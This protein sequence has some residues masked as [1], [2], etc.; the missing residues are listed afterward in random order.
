MKAAGKRT[1]AK[2]R[3]AAARQPDLFATF[4]P[5][6]SPDP[7]EAPG[8]PESP[9]SFAL[10]FFDLGK[11]KACAAS[12]GKD[13]LD[14]RGMPQVLSLTS[15]DAFELTPDGE[16]ATV[17]A[18]PRQGAHGREFLELAQG[19]PLQTRTTLAQGLFARGAS[20][21]T[22][23]A[24]LGISI[25]T[26][27]DWMHHY[28]NGTY[29]T[30]LVPGRR[31]PMRFDESIKARVLHMRADR[32]LS[33]NQIVRETGISRATIRRWISSRDPSL[34]PDMLQCAAE[35]DEAAVK[36]E[37]SEKEK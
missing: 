36:S 37:K 5:P 3:E 29:E 14:L 8:S 11:D 33:Y 19:L 24:S 9:E 27:R 17:S 15:A 16:K 18:D 34:G 30:L 28:R 22:V 2:R 26:A 23:A 20:Y 13:A 7:A 1:S 32:G 25:Y 31:G 6:D 10:E 21:K 4:D 12:A 35:A